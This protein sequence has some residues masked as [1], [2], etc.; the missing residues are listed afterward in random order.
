MQTYQE[1]LA[2]KRLVVQPIG[3]DTSQD[4][5]NPLLFDFQRDLVVW[6]VRKGR[7][8][9]FLDTGL[10]KTFCQLEWARLIG[11]RTLII[12]PLTVTRQTVSEAT[13]LGIDVRYVRSGDQV[14][15]DHQF[16]ITNYEMIEHFDAADFGAVVLDESS[17]LKSLDGKTR[18]LLTAKFANTPYRLC[19][20]ATPAPNDVTEIGRHAEFLG[21]MKNEEML[22]AFFVNDQKMKDGTYRLKG[23]AVN[24]FYEWLTSWGIAIKKPSDIGYLDDGYQLPPLTVT[25]LF[26][27]SDYT[28]EG[29]LPG[30]GVGSISAIEAKRVR[31]TTIDS[32]QQVAID[33]IAAD[34]DQWVI[35][36]GLND[37]A[38]TLAANIPNSVNVYGA[39]SPDEKTEALE[40]FI[41]G[42]VRVLIT[43]TSIAGFGINMQSCHKTLFFGMDYSWESYYQAVRRFY[44]FGQTMPVDV[45]VLIS[46]V[47]R[48]IL[49]TVMAKEQEAIKMTTEMVNR[50]SR[51]AQAEITGVVEMEWTYREDAKNGEK[52]QMLLGD[53]C[54]RINEIEDN[55]VD[56]SVFSPPF[57]S[58]YT[59]TPTERDLG[60][61]RNE[62]EFFAHFKPIID[63]LLR[64]TKPGRN[65]CVHVQQVAATKVNDGYI[66]IKDFRGDVIRAF[67]G[68]GFIFH[69]E[70]TIDKNPQVQAIRTKTKG[71]M[72]AQLHKDS[73]ANRPAF[74]DYL[75]I[76]QKAGENEVAVVPDVTNEEWITW[77]HPVWYDISETD[78]LNVAVARAD[79][80][81][82][83][84]C[85]LQLP[86]IE[87]CVRL[88]SNP[89]ELVF[90]PFGGI[91]SEGYESLRHGRRFIGIELKPEY[92]SVACRNL[93]EAERQSNQVDLF[94]WAAM[95][96]ETDE[97]AS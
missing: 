45:F 62:D 21:V 97:A 59:Y 93:Q 44:R 86:F 66:G 25:P 60:N 43:K 39:M 52:W 17:I 58:L 26:V 35:W 67:T 11:Q 20:S 48:P 89:G 56:L 41:A 85:A 42:D 4:Q 95:Q 65:C 14:T 29:M 54:E 73:A 51:Y 7:C 15:S 31:R 5:V 24:R 10:G 12:A 38:E 69:G 70:V 77:A 92:W 50:S 16:F 96:Q 82:R 71:L 57:V 80:D 19:C 40:R 23:H 63:G 75:L 8:A 83:H 46:E 87:R 1:F 74:G 47:E 53:S 13:K 18:K 30:F 72:F 90:S 61:S 91:G 64:I 49:D 36:T 9:L 32:R 22:S 94:Q 79:Q 68:A 3:V 55:S 28:P 27:N 37:E 34:N 84:M 33:L 88:Y 78:V 6:A 2:S 81:E 76:F